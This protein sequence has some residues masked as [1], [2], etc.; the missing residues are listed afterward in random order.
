VDGFDF[1]GEPIISGREAENENGVDVELVSRNADVST[2]VFLGY[3]VYRSL[4]ATIHEPNT[5][6]RIGTNLS[7]ESHSE[8]MSVLTDADYR[9]IVRAIYSNDNFSHPAFSNIVNKNKVSEYEEI[10]LPLA[11]RLLGNFPNPF[12]RDYD[13]V[14]D[15]ECVSFAE[16]VACG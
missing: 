13:I 6:V 9:Y 4:Q 12:N 11:N 1:N 3:N 16:C 15:I 7:T 14:Y 5:W 10:E 2:R 8:N